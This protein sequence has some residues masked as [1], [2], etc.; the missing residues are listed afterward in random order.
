MALKRPVRYSVKHPS[1]FGPRGIRRHGAS[2][3]IHRSAWRDRLI[4]PEKPPFWDA[5]PH[6]WITGPRAPLHIAVARMARTR[7]PKNC[8]L[9]PFSNL[10]SGEHE[11]EKH[12]GENI[13]GLATIE[14]R[15]CYRKR[16]CAMAVRSDATNPTRKEPSP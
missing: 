8:R 16:R 6:L 12:E 3:A 15:K 4:N 11:G 5:H 7:S 13:G 2:Y 14:R 10:L 1:T 9:G